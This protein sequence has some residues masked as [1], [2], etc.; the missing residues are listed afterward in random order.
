MLLSFGILVFTIIGVFL[1]NGK[2]TFLIA[3]FN[4][5]SQEDKEKY[6]KLALGKFYGKTILALSASMV[7]WVLSDILKN[8]VLFIIGLI[9]FVTIIIFS[10][11]YSNLGDRFKKE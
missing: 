10:L 9:L 1:L 4:M 5:L 11:I 8:D 6:D 2:G 7:F 3:G